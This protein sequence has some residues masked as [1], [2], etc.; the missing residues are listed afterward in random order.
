MNLA[1]IGDSDVSS[2]TWI[3]YSLSST[4]LHMQQDAAIF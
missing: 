1:K 3:I 2:L 4:K